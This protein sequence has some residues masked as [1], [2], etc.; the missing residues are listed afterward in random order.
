MTLTVTDLRVHYRT[1]R[2]EVRALDGV[3]FDLADGEILGLAGESGCG[4]TTLGKSLIRLDGRM[5]HAGGTVTL[6]G[7]DVPIADDRAMNA[8]R[9]H[10]IS[11]V[12]QYSMS[13]LNP[14]RRIGRMIREL[15]ASRGV[16]VDTD[17][18]HR[19]LDLVGLDHDVLNRYPIELSGGM[20][21]RTVMVI[22]TLLDPAVLVA[23][24]VTSALDVSTQ[25][26]VV[27]AL[28]GL[29][30]KGLVTSMIF[31]THD[32]G[33]TSHIADSIMVMYAGRAAEKA[34]AKV[35]TTE[36]RHPYTKLL[37]G[38]LPEVGARYADKP[39][40]GIAGSPPSLLDPPAGCRFRDR[41]PL[42]DG[43]CAEEPPVVEVAPRHSV[44]C[45]KAA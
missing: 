44:A 4:K 14:T 26:A 24:E 32:L 35:L 27:G 3:S 36:P 25:R 9:F 15:L 12:P 21:Q 11:L 33:L 41:C 23:D 42:A 1:L 7:D 2:G 17:E 37:L 38:S 28:T 18:L 13:A 45:W 29:R 40:K 6:D 5:R 20:K 43:R 10:R 22:S 16:G 34:P 31:V 30:D 39:L 19:R 8:F